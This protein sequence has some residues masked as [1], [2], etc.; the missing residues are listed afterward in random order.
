M[1]ANVEF[2]RARREK[3]DAL[4]ITDPKPV[5]SVD[6]IWASAAQ[7]ATIGIF[8]IV[9]GMCFHFCRPVL[10]PVLAAV[11]VGMTLAPLVK[12][13]ARYGISPWVSAIALGLV[14]KIGRASCRESV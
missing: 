4:T 12:G 1:E 5:E 10:L 6:D 3:G 8:V 2:L 9:L 14:L 13:A 7:M 11:V